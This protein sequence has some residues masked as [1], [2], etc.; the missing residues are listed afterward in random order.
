MKSLKLA[1]YALAAGLFLFSANSCTNNIKDLESIVY[2]VSNKNSTFKTYGRNI[3]YYNF[4]ELPENQIPEEYIKMPYDLEKCVNNEINRPDITDPS[5]FRREVLKEAEK[6]G[7]TEEMLKSLSVKE[8]IF[9]AVKITGSKINYHLV[10][11]DPEFLSKYGSKISTDDYFYIGL[12]DCDKYRNITI[13]IFEIMKSINHNLKNVYLASEELGGYMDFHAWVSIVI[14]CKENLIL[15]HVDPTFYDNGGKFEAGEKH[16]MIENEAYKAYLYKELYDC[17]NAYM[18]FEESIK[19]QN[20]DDVLERLLE[21]TSFTLYLFSDDNSKFVVERIENI[22]QMYEA[23][24]FKD[25]LD[26]MLYRSFIIYKDAGNK[27]RSEYYKQRLL[28][29]FPDS[30]WVGEIKKHKK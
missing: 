16:V 1:C 7:Y 10:D 20:D 3:K 8:A 26:S 14:P 9:T 22:N 29:E 28:T 18:F 17:E 5:R 12:G 11:S 2:N 4:S 23:K 25:R 21:D 13:R 19:K 6:L 27:E 24:G 15:C 30:Y